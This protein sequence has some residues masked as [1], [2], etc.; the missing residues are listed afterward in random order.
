MGDSLWDVCQ[1]VADAGAQAGVADTREHDP[2]HVLR[3]FLAALP[4]LVGANAACLDEA[5]R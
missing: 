2:R 4:R 1:V 5:R 3:E